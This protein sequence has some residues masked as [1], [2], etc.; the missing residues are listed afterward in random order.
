MSDLAKAYIIGVRHNLVQ[1]LNSSSFSE[2]KIEDVILAHFQAWPYSYSV[3]PPRAKTI[4]YL[5]GDLQ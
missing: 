1:S 3:D 2:L 4:M 5:L